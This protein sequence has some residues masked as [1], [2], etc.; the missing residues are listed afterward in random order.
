MINIKL[1]RARLTCSKV[2]AKAKS[3]DFGFDVKDLREMTE[4]I[5]RLR[6]NDR[7]LPLLNPLDRYPMIFATVPSHGQCRY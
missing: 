1:D 3:L 2:C 4:R 5:G 6:E 7:N